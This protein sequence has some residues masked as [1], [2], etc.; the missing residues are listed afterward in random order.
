M[1]LK[2]TRPLSNGYKNNFIAANKDYITIPKDYGAVNHVDLDYSVTWFHNDSM[3]NEAL[4]NVGQNTNPTTGS[5]LCL[6]IG[7]NLRFYIKT[8][9]V[10]ESHVIV[11]ADLKD[12]INTIDIIGLKLFLNGN[13]RH[14]FAD[15]GALSFDYLYPLTFGKLSYAG[16]YYLNSSAYTFRFMGETF[17][18]DEKSGYRVYGNKGSFGT[19]VTSNAGGLAYINSNVIEKLPVFKN[20]LVKANNDFIALN[21]NFIIGDKDILKIRFSA[22]STFSFLFGN[23]ASLTYF[24]LFNTSSIQVRGS[25]GIS[26]TFIASFNLDQ[27]YDLRLERNIDDLTLYIDNIFIST[28]AL[29]AAEV[30]DFNQLGLRGNSGAEDADITIY[31]FQLNNETFNLDEKSGYRVY[32]NQ[33]SFGTRITSNAGGLAY[34]NSNVIQKI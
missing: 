12:G 10:Q 11:R 16:L 19:R 9:G 22:Q 26:K 4:L 8:G 13:L 25:T 17:S 2:T 28:E 18:L 30:L 34:I 14:T 33:G 29:G 5:I 7:T 24:I 3:A 1:L 15:K 27:V 21:S 23:N 20:T 32:G 6:Y 31:S